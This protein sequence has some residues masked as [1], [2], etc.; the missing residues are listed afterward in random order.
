MKTSST[1]QDLKAAL[2]AIGYDTL[3]LLVT[4][5]Q[6]GTP[7]SRLRYY[8]LARRGGSHF[9]PEDKVWRS[10]PGQREGVHVATIKEYLDTD[11]FEASRVPDKVLRKWGRLFDIV[12]PSSERSCCFTR[13]YRHLVE[14]SGSV[15]Q[16]V[17]ELDVCAG[18][19]LFA[20]PLTTRFR[21]LKY[22]TSS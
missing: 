7:N 14:R 3:E 9:P 21:R 8:M 10:I 4:P 12:K 16:E 11:V 17:D 19:L 1:R 15:L 20:Y 5:L 13:A 6:Y 18:P 2:K 22:S